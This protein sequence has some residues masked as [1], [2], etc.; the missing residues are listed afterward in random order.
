[1]APRR[2]K[3]RGSMRLFDRAESRRPSRRT[4]QNLPFHRPSRRL[5]TADDPPGIRRHPLPEPLK[6]AA[7]RHPAPGVFPEASL[8]VPARTGRR[9]ARPSGPGT[10]RT[11]P[12]Q[13]YDGRGSTLALPC[14][15]CSLLAQRH[16]AP[17]RRFGIARGH[18]LST[19][20]PAALVAAAFPA[21][22]HRSSCS[23][24]SMPPRR[25]SRPA[26][27]GPR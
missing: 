22:T 13:R 6:P 26:S 2:R 17:A 16:L 19:R 27:S 20:Q 23:S 9:T 5:R 14:T 3:P 8:P 11:G 12:L 24:G 10:R 21:R 4:R 18:R 15:P 25:D 1:M 7:A